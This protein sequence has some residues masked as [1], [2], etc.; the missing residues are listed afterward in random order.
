MLAY[1]LFVLLGVG[2]LFP[3]NA[4]LTALDYFNDLYTDFPFIFA[5]SLFY[6]YPSVIFLLLNIKFGP[7]YD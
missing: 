6:N 2:V 5:V 3:W 4:F 1:L 7:K